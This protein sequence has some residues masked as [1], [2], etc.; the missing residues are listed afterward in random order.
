MGRPHTELGICIKQNCFHRAQSDEESLKGVSISFITY[1]T[2]VCS[3][4]LLNPIS[5]FKMQKEIREQTSFEIE[6]SIN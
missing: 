6:I 2:L 5:D 3:V 1:Y 4:L